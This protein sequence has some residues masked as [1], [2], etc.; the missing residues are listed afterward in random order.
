MERSTWEGVEVPGSELS[1][2]SEGI[3]E[4]YDDVFG[5]ALQGENACCWSCGGVVVIA[6]HC[7]LRTFPATQCLQASTHPMH[8]R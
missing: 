8:L 5:K 6:H 1:K 7:T 3:E 2:Y 4:D